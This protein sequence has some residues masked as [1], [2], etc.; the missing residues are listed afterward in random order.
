MS[1]KTAYWD[2]EAAD[3][4]EADL[5]GRL[6]SIDPTS[7]AGNGTPLADAAATLLASDIMQSGVG[8]DVAARLTEEQL[9]TVM[10]TVKNVLDEETWHRNLSMPFGTDVTVYEHDLGIVI[11]GDQEFVLVDTM[12]GMF[13]RHEVPTDPTGP[14]LERFLAHLL[15]ATSGWPSSAIGLPTVVAGG[16]MFEGMVV[17]H[18]LRFP[19]CAAAGGV[20]LDIELNR[21]INQQTHR[22]LH[23]L[24]DE[25]KST[26]DMFWDLRGRLSAR[27]KRARSTFATAVAHAGP[28]AAGLALVELLARSDTTIDE[29]GHTTEVALEMHIGV[30]SFDGALRPSVCHYV[31]NPSGYAKRATELAVRGHAP[32]ALRVSEGPTLHIEALAAAFARAAPGGLA[33][34]LGRLAHELGTDVA[35]P[36]TGGRLLVTRLLWR[37]GVISAR[38]NTL[39]QMSYFG[40]K[41]SLSD[42]VL[43][44]TLRQSLIGRNL[45]QVLKLPLSCPIEICGMER[46][47]SGEIKLKLRNELR[48]VDLALGTIADEPDVIEG[49]CC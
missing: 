45:D 43:P 49:P 36:L 1:E 48:V 26:M 34:V 3:A 28:A 11:L 14:N 29:E 40:D 24:V 41:V 31:T 37:D 12:P 8:L 42:V 18:R 9:I 15:Q 19:A 39:R 5:R 32:R 21:P 13:R 22:A 20:C 30:S 4:L 25:A 7:C 44:Q 38:G 16:G 23:D 10:S 47:D 6:R 33:A 27:A 17:T 2:R 35:L 46:T